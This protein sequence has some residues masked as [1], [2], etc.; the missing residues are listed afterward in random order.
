MPRPTDYDPEYHPQK[1][2]EYMSQGMLD[3]E[4]YA[5]FDISKNTFIRWKKE[6]PEFN[7]A[8]EKGLPKCESVSVIKPL[9]QMVA[10]QTDKGYKALSHIARNKFGHD[11]PNHVA[12][13]NTQINIGQVTINNK[14]DYDRLALEVKD[15]L[16]NLNI[17]D[18]ELIEYKKEDDNS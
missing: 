16:L 18:A 14:E 5:E 10:D 8:Y 7:E 3:C 17:V 13:T 9:K 6:Y 15:Q 4:I 2:L 1:V 12:T 11:A